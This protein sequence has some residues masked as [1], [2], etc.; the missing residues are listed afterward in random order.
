MG[1]GAIKLGL[2]RNSGSN[3]F[4]FS[5]TGASSLTRRGSHQAKIFTKLG[6][7]S[8][9]VSWERIQ[10]RLVRRKLEAISVGF[11]S[12]RWENHKTR[13]PTKVRSG[14][15]TLL[16]VKRSWKQKFCL[17]LKIQ[18]NFRLDFE[19]ML[20]KRYEQIFRGKVYQEHKVGD[21][22]NV[23]KNLVF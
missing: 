19:K 23:Q 20:R 21:F 10:S 14:S 9:I 6:I 1:R 12:K 16:S 11:L 22:W 5:A 18:R 4:S 8:W 15:E 7:V 3:C 2:L 13:A 17:R